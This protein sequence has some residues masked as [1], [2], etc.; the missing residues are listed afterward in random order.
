M[1]YSFFNDK[2][3]LNNVIEPHPLADE[4]RVFESLS[5]W[6]LVD[7]YCAM[8][9]KVGEDPNTYGNRVAFIEKTARVRLLTKDEQ[10][11]SLYKSSEYGLCEESLIAC[12]DKLTQLGFV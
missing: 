4:Q 11:E 5:P 10:W 2:S 6:V 12:D 8:R 3:I 1:T 9:Y 7:G